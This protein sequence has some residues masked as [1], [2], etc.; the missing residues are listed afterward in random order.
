VKRLKLSPAAD[1]F[2]VTGNDDGV[3]VGGRE[4]AEMSLSVW[5]GP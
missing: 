5:A 1:R 3:V 2:A 4:V